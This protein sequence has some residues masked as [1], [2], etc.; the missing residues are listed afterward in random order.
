LPGWLVV[1]QLVKRPIR[2]L[3]KEFRLRKGNENGGWSWHISR[4]GPGN[5]L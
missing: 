4:S 1:S 5:R 2:T 3:V